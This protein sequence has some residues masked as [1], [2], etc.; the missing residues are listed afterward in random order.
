MSLTL[1]KSCLLPHLRMPER[2]A[3][4]VTYVTAVRE[5]AGAPPATERQLADAFDT[6][7]RFGYNG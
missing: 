1:D 6:L 2:F 7:E 5:K 4:F 3:E